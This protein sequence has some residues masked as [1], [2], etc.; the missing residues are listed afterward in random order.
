MGVLILVCK[1][2]HECLDGKIVQG[3]IVSRRSKPG[4]TPLVTECPD[5]VDV[6]V[7][8]SNRLENKN[9]CTFRYFHLFFLYLD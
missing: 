2:P 5:S 4:V 7:K 6:R 3:S 1:T 9:F 8:G